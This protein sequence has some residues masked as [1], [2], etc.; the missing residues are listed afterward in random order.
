MRTEHI[1]DLVSRRHRAKDFLCGHYADRKTFWSTAQAQTP[2]ANLIRKVQHVN[3][4][5]NWYQDNLY[6]CIAVSPNRL[7]L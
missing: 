7:Q 1:Q 2:A 4:P 3:Y 5:F 6:E